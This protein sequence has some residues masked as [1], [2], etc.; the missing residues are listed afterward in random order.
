[1]SEFVPS[2][3]SVT[4]F[5]LFFFFCI[6]HFNLHYKITLQLESPGITKEAIQ[7][8][9]FVL[10]NKYIFFISLFLSFLPLIPRER[11][12]SNFRSFCK[13]LYFSFP[14]LKS[15]LLLLGFPDL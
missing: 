2:A 8:Q 14:L 12:L 5:F 13:W 6:G 4:S 7:F 1:M 15:Q 9:I 11:S 3:A 10:A